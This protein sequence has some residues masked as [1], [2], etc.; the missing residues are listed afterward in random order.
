MSSGQWPFP[1]DSPIAR[2]RKVGLAYRTLAQ[3]LTK[4]LHDAGITV[5]TAVADLDERFTDWGEKWHCEQVKSLGPDDLV[6]RNEAAALIGVA[7]GTLG[8][9]RIRGRIK[10]QWVKGVFGKPGHYLYKVSDVYQLST[11]LRGR[12]WRAADATDTVTPDGES[13]TK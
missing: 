5:E 10:G 8:R 7:G 3:D 4:Q 6:D 13:D 11:E 12:S 1:G 9:L 2:A